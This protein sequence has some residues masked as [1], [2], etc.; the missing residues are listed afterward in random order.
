MCKNR[1]MHFYFTVTDIHRCK[2]RFRLCLF[3]PTVC[4]HNLK[5]FFTP[6]ALTLDSYFGCMIL[7]LL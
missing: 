3:A 2:K 5:L 4:S 1:A 6:L 7:Q